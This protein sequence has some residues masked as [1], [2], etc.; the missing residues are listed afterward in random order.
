MNP[1]IDRRT[2][3]FGSLAAATLGPSIARAAQTPDKLRLGIIGCAGQGE[4]N[5]SN[6]ADQEIVMLCDV[7]LARAAKAKQQFPGAEVVQDFR[8][9]IDNKNIDAVVVSTPDHWHA[10]PSVWAMES[11]KHVYCEKPLAHDVHEVRVMMETARKQK[12]VTQMG[13]QI[14]AGANYRRVV[15][16][17]QAGAIGKVRK[18]D[19]WVGS[20][21]VLGKRE[22]Q[23]EV[24]STLDYELWAGPSPKLP[25]NS[26]IVPFHWR[27]W[28]EYGGGVLA[29]LACHYMDLPHWA[30]D[31]RQPKRVFAIGT[32]MPGADRQVPAEMKV[33]FNY[34]GRD[35]QPPVEL[36]WWHGTNG[37]RGEDGQVRN[38]F[39]YGSGVMFHGDEGE[40]I[41][42][43][44]RHK[45]LPE[46]K[47]ADYKRPE[48][49]IPDSVGHHKAGVQA[50][51]NGGPTT[52]NF[53]YSGALAE[54][55]LLG[56]VSYHLGREIEWDHKKGRVKNVP[57]K[58]WETLIQRPYRAGWTLKP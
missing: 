29:D 5:W 34:P 33:V 54:T 30:L 40:L 56:N 48:P 35:G 51:V 14:H 11:G 32:E 31:L 3:L 49:T 26:A 43:Y 58:D 1:S 6:V 20:R 57:K 25:F 45:L 37:P 53:Q 9:V 8:R 47:Y 21:P 4:Y 46:A 24:P 36:T 17:V 19:V 55:V 7:D 12:R 27:W 2:F 16:L 10:I 50:I 13:T 15:E 23:G 41:A 44:S 38:L 28:W 18:V 52:C 39:G 22:A 42:D